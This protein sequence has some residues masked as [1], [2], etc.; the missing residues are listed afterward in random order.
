M[1]R[2]GGC[3]GSPSALTNKFVYGPISWELIFSSRLHR[4]FDL[5]S[6]VPRMPEATPEVQAQQVKEMPEFPGSTNPFS[7]RGTM[8]SGVDPTPNPLWLSPPGQCTK[9]ICKQQDNTWKVR[10]IKLYF[11]PAV[12]ELITTPKFLA[13]IHSFLQY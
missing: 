2:Q 12:T 11:M 3:S 4:G 7:L 8:D 13:P 9:M 6:S 5:L 1:G 10:E